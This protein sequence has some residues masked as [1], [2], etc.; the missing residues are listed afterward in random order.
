MATLDVSEIVNDPELAEP[1]IIRRSRGGFV[2]GGWSDQITEIPAYGVVS[3]A[4]EKDLEVLPE[5]DRVR[6]A[7]VFHSSQPIYITNAEN[8][9]VSDVLVWNNVAYRVLS[10]AD[11]SNRGYYRAVACRT[12]GN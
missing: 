9:G 8:V 1:F 11:Y 12:A 6:E 2:R 7:R 4:A 10:V 3:V 5:G